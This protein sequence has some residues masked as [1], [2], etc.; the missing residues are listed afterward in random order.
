MHD[1]DAIGL[2]QDPA[3]RALYD[4]VARQ[5]REVGRNEAAEAVGIQ[6]TLAAFHLDR[7]ADGGLLE[8]GYTRL[9]Q[10]Q[11]PGAGRPAKLYRVAQTEHAVAVP[12]RDYGRAAH[13]LA[14]AIERTGAEEGLYAAARQQGVQAGATLDDK[15]LIREL[16]QRGY[17]PH[18]E[19][20]GEIRLRNCPFHTLA[21][22]YPVIAC[23]MN[24]ALL[25]GL[26]SG[27]QLDHQHS[28]RLD[29]RP[30]ECCV[31]IISKTNEH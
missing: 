8:V 1:L 29:P 9:G 7:L 15:Q 19:A 23:G 28:A 30:G 14:E 5:G 31:T 6:R 24:L 4:Y 27:A 20:D 22:N 13:V 17:A 26:L 2:L 21:Q 16:S 10:R 11:G 25:E 12:P 18:V 3:R